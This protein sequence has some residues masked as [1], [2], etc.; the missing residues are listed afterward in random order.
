MKRRPP[1]AKAAERNR[2]GA[3][4]SVWRRVVDFVVDRD[5]GLCH[6]C[7]HPGAKSADHDPFPVTERPDLAMSASNLKA[8]HGWPNA[9]PVCS[10]AS[11]ARGGKR[12]YCNELKSSGT[13]ERA[14]RIISERTG[15]VL[16]SKTGDQASGERDWDSM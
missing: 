6:V 7:R 3:E 8:V 1:R 14:R 5:L 2:N 13:T 10:A 15:L 16:D 12:I 4:G 11:Q 9:C